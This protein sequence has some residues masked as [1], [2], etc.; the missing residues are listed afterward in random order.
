MQLLPLTKTYGYVIYTHSIVYADKIEKALAKLKTQQAQLLINDDAQNQ[1]KNIEAKRLKLL[2]L[3]YELIGDQTKRKRFQYFLPG[4]M[5]RQ[6]QQQ[7]SSR[8]QYRFHSY[9]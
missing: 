1:I 9:S 3:Q 4:V 5:N 2:E 7:S 6:I 8:Y